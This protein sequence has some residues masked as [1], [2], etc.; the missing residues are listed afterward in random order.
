MIDLSDFPFLLVPQPDRRQTPD[1]RHDRRGGRRASDC[2]GFAVSSAIAADEELAQVFATWGPVLRSGSA[3]ID[4]L[5][6]R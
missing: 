3:C 2:A 6:V 4:P 1:R 5:A